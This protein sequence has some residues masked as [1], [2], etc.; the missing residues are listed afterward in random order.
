MA[1][2]RVSAAEGYALWADTWDTTPSPI[3]AL[4][5]RMLRPWLE[6]LQPRRAIDVGCGTGRWSARLDALGFDASAAMLAVAARKPS[7]AGRLAVADA[8]ALPLAS[9][10]AGL[11]LCAL[12][13]GHIPR[14]AAAMRE[15]AR[16]LEP[17]GVLIVTDFHPEAAAAGWRRTFRRDGQLYELENHAYTVD[18]LRATLAGALVCEEVRNA[19]IGEPERHLFDL[20]GRPELFDAACALPAVLLSRW[21]RL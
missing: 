11:V 15:F 6:G 2:V 14:P 21:R 3:A 1:A 9:A 16:I 12:T 5:E 4:E 19:R 17:G 10:C 13:L 18:A 20:A 8:A 7:L